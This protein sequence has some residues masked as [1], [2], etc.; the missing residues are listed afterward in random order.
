MKLEYRHIKE[1]DKKEICDWKYSGEYAIYNLLPYEKQAELKRGFCNKDCEKNYYSFFEG[2]NL[3]SF[4]QLHEEEKEVF[5]GVGVNP[6][7]VNMGYGK[8]SIKIA[9]DISRS[10]YKDKPIYLEVRTWNKRAI[11]CYKSA[12]FEIDGESYKL[13]TYIGEGEFY[14]MVR[15]F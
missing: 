3:V 1:A 9:C 11:N 8:K 15:E 12:G 4:I 13:T 7:Y 10:L 14:R 2:D 5:L 6:K